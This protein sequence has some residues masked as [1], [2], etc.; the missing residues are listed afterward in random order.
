MYFDLPSATTTLSGA[1]EWFN[2]LFD[3]FFP[4][5]LIAIGVS[6]FFGGIGWLISMFRDRFHR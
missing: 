5:A 2:P 4:W 1:A 6:L 3:E